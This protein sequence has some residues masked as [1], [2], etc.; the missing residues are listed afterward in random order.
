MSLRFHEIAEARHRILNP[1]TDGKLMLLGD[2]CRLRPGQRILDLAC[3]KAELLARWAAEW[4]VGGVGV[5]ISEV[6]VPAGRRRVADLGVADR[7]EI[8]RGDAS[9]YR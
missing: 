1:L 4:G 5:D 6:F 7:V 8:V 2:I 9:A 3:G